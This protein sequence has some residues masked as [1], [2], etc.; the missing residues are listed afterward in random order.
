MSPPVSRYLSPVNS[1]TWEVD[2]NLNHPS[3]TVN[4]T[5]ETRLQTGMSTTYAIMGAGLCGWNGVKR[6][7]PWHIYKIYIQPKTL[8][9]LE[10]MNVTG[11]KAS[12]YR[13][14]VS[15]RTFLRNILTLPDRAANTALHI[16]LGCLPVEAIIEQRQF[17]LITSIIQN[18]LILELIIR[19]IT[20][21][22]LKC[23]SWVVA[24]KKL[25]RRY[26]LP[27]LLEVISQYCSTK[28]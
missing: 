28:E 26:N 1:H 12:L 17:I 19:Q 6:I 20:V 11:N 8:F 18:A 5:V 24:T 21:K 3:A 15:L 16:M 13:L 10:T 2:Y 25:L 22:S 7:T 27:S 14:G 23:T 9:S 4:R